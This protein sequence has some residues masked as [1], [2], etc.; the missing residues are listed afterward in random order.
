MLKAYELQNCPDP[1]PFQNGY[2][3]NSDYSV[4]QSLS[5]ECYPGYI[6]IGYPV[7][8]CQHGINRN[9]N[10]PFPRCDAPC[11]YNVTSQNG[12]I[13]SPGFPDE[14]PILKDCIWLIT[15]PPGHGVYINFTLLQTE[16]S[17]TLSPRL[18]CSGVIS[19]H[20][21]LHFPGSSNSPASASRAARTT[22]ACH[23]AWLIFVILV[24]MGFHHVGQAGLKLLTSGGLPTLASQ[25]AG[26]TDVSYCAWR[27]LACDQDGPDQNS[28]QL[29]VF[30][31]NTALE[32]AY[33]STNQVLLKFH[34]DFS[35]GGF[36]VLNF[37]GDFVKYQCHPGYTLVGTDTLTCKLSSQLQ[38]EGSPPTC[39]EMSFC[40]G[41]QA[42]LE[43]QDS[44]DPPALASQIARFAVISD[45]TQPAPNLYLC[46]DPIAMKLT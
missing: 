16:A 13:Y 29:G 10:Y 23:H 20:C 15:V 38:F 31:G 45:C 32:T 33:S 8:T 35:N 25:S 46:L 19:A 5:F 17:L 28:P 18:E 2:M 30:S 43:L 42:G 3:I 34:S 6:L 41:T 21:N 12:T 24:E 4:G 1:P 26:I 44:S 37:H 7:L 36:F 22:S 27:L 39:E 11:G 40:H 9:W 14:Y